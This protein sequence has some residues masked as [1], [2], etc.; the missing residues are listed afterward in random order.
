MFTNIRASLSKWNEKTSPLKQTLGRH[1]ISTCCPLN[2]SV[3]LLSLGLSFVSCFHGVGSGLS[4]TTRLLKQASP[5]NTWTD[6][7][8]F[9]MVSV[10]FPHCSKHPIQQGKK[11]LASCYLFQFSFLMA[12]R[13]W[14]RTERNSSQFASLEAEKGWWGCAA[15][16]AFCLLLLSFSQALPY[17]ILPLTIRAGL[18]TWVDPPWKHLHK[19]QVFRFILIFLHVYVCVFV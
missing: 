16:T 4:R 5:G 6:F 13:L 15:V 12:E 9:L 1:S 7:E 18:P 14:Q 17:G 11:D 10:D 3:G 2:H 8:Y 19:M